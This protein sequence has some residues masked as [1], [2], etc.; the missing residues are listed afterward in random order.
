MQKRKPLINFAVSLIIILCVAGIV[1]AFAGGPPTGAT[2]SVIFNQ[3]SCA[4]AGCHAGMAV[5][6]SSGS[7][8]LSGVPASYSLGQTYDLTVTIN[9]PNQRRWGFQLSARARTSTASVGS[10]QSL[11]G[12]SQ[13]QT[14]SGIQYIAHNAAGTRAGT[15]G[16]VSFQVRWTAPSTS[17][18]EVV[19]SVA[20][21]AANNDN[22]NTGDFIHFRET[23]SQPPGSSAV[24]TITSVS[25]SSGP[26][27]GGTPVIITGTG[28]AS[29]ATVTVGGVA[30]TNVSVASATQ[31]NAT[32]GA[33]GTPGTVNVVV[34]VSGQSATLNGGFT[35]SS[36]T[37]TPAPTSSAII[38]PFIVDTTAFRANLI[39]SNLTGATA[40]VTVQ[41]VEAGGT[42]GGSKSY[43]V[44]PNGLKQVNRVIADVLNLASPTGKQGYLILES[45]QRITAAATPID[46]TTIDSAVIQ[47]SR[48]TSGHLLSLTSASVAGFLTTMTIVNDS[49]VANNVE[50]RLR[51]TDGSAA[52]VKNVTIAAY[53]QFHTEDVHQ[54]MGATGT[55]GP[56]ELTSKNASPQPIIAV[57]R[58]YSTITTT[59]PNVGI[60]QTSSFFS[61]VPY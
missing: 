54:F 19:F 49:L 45:D 22:N 25:P 41:F 23:T 14:L 3:Q 33:A 48:G 35:Y 24:P 26:V 8:T 55:V 16:P 53:G 34:T 17:A 6:S 51:P 42:I 43:T 9:Q 40:N 13:L 38:L 7:L 61:A 58:V 30:A 31:I 50:L 2:G 10:L 57:S 27:N 18:G 39:M 4:Q 59:S 46:N 28:F 60:G 11:D 44:D 32:T 20:G 36:S 37:S 12:F 47:G 21:N 15:V 29:G 52:V 1:F 5:N 56:I